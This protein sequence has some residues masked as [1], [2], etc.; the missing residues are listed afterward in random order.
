MLKKISFALLPLLIVSLNTNLYAESNSDNAVIL[1]MHN[2]VQLKKKHTAWKTAHIDNGLSI[3]DAIRTGVASRAEI[4]Y[5]DGT[6][7]RL[8]SSSIMRIDS[9]D[10]NRTGIKLLLGKLWLKVTK[11][12]GK[13]K[14]Y[15]PT[16]TATVLGT[17]LFVSNNEKNISH[18]TT[19]EGLVEVVDNQGDKTLVKPGEWVE[20]TPG[21]KMEQPT[22][23]DWD[24]L[25]KA[26]RFMLDPN[27]KPSLDDFKDE[28][29]WR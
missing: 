19:L 5:A 2:K 22:K 7:T 8:G 10:T 15:T 28:S 4:K 25:K 18:I 16:A 1:D 23:F 26:E 20:I 27:F 24:E 21:Q 11:G 14:I 13:L 6:I 3:G 29:N 12:S 9:K 17:E